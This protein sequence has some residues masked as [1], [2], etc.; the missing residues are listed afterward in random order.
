MF[1]F[2][3]NKE[4]FR[5]SLLIPLVQKSSK[6]T[7]KTKRTTRKA[8]NNLSIHE[9]ATEIAIISFSSLQ[10][11]SF[12]TSFHVFQRPG[13]RIIIGLINFN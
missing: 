7:L 9:Q 2:G 6:F 1:R 10:M 13:R 3:S 4:K 12:L 11:K 5:V 8:G